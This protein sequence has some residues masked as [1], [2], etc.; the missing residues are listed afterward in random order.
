MAAGGTPSTGS[1][2]PLSWPAA[3]YTVAGLHAGPA[4]VAF[5]IHAAFQ[6]TCCKVSTS[7]QLAT[8]AASSGGSSGGSSWQLTSS[9]AA[10]GASSV[11]AAAAACVLATVAWRHARPAPA[12][13]APLGRSRGASAAASEAGEGGHSGGGGGSG[14]LSRA[15]EAAWRFRAA[16]AG[17]GWRRL[18][19][20]LLTCTV[21]QLSVVACI[22]WAAA[23]AALIM[24]VPWLCAAGPLPLGRRDSRVAERGSFLGLALLSPWS[25]ASAL[26]GLAA[27]R[28]GTVLA[29]VLHDVTG[30]RQAAQPAGL[31]AAL[32]AGAQSVLRLLA[33]SPVLA[34]LLLGV[35]APA[36][37]CC[38]LI[39]AA[40]S[41]S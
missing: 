36:W 10:G 28:N 26:G 39:A 12:R 4:A 16:L 22:D 34:A 25:V 2:A 11:A 1:G 38:A 29:D 14:V 30:W 9:V 33:A 24:L 3:L 21:V 37:L 32:S 35:W 17:S 20:A 31:L 6:P 5:A 8:Q 18:K 41:D 7:T 27:A 19:A 13:L 23:A 15:A 40:P